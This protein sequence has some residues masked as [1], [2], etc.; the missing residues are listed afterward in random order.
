MCTRG[1]VLAHVRGQVGIRVNGASNG[2]HCGVTKM[3]RPIRVLVADDHG[4]MREAIRLALKPEC[5][6]EVAGQAERGDEV[7][8]RIRET[9]PNVL[10]LD[11]RMPGMDGLEVLSRVRAQFPD[12]KV[13]MLSAVDE[14]E[15][16]AQALELGAVA[17]LGKRVEPSALVS[18]IHE[19]MDGT[20][21]TETIA[22][23]DGPKDA[24]REAALSPREVE[25]LRRVASGRSN[26]EIAQELWL[27]EQTVKYH[28]T[29]VYR[30]IQVS[31][32][33]DAT[34][35]AYEHALADRFSA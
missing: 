17:Y 23:R 7:L 20:V 4:L 19:I 24:A 35:Y 34:R 25:I 28:L 26:R 12:V 14:P 18:T 2:F 13:A 16:A 10:L 33:T 15:V 29:N 11:I 5:D 6:I 27:S 9:R 8:P 30:K 31:G 3:K 32:R 21:S 22:L 1:V